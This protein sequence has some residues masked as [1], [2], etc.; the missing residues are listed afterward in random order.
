M[1]KHELEQL[2]EHLKGSKK[3]EEKALKTKVQELLLKLKDSTS[4]KEPKLKLNC[5]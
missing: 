2:L 4:P 1:D 3:K 5:L